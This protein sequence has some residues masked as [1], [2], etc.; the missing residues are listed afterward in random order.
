MKKQKPAD[1][2]VEGKQNGAGN[3]T[4]SPS[5]VI[6]VLCVGVLRVENQ[7]I[8]AAEEIRRD[9]FAPRSQF[10][11][12]LPDSGHWPSQRVKIGRARGPAEKRLS[13]RW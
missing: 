12:L 9:R 10:F 11:S 3:R 1:L 13:R 5:D 2:G 6:F 4:V 8:A 7:N